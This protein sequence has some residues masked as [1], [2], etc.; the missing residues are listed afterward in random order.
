MTDRLGFL[1]ILPEEFPLPNDQYL[2]LRADVYAAACG[3]SD[4]RTENGQTVA[5]ELS[6]A[7]HHLESAWAL[8]LGIEEAERRREWDE[9]ARENSISPDRK[10]EIPDHA[11]GKRTS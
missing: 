6:K 3:F 4:L 2:R 7:Q 9:E 11:A 5:R 10:F 1:D 8:I